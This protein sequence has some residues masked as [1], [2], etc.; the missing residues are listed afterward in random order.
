MP[1]GKYESVVAFKTLEHSI[2]YNTSHWPGERQKCTFQNPI[3]VLFA[4]T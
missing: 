4:A 1:L 2:S 3:H